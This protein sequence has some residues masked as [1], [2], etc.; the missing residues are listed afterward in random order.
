VSTLAITRRSVAAVTALVALLT[1][2]VLLVAASP[3]HAHSELVSSTPAEG[4]SV[5][6][7]GQLSLTFGEAIEPEF[8]K[9]TLTGSNNQTISLGTPKYDVAKTT[10]AI[11]VTQIVGGGTYVIGYSVLSVDGHTVAGK[12][13]FTST[14]ATMGGGMHGPDGDHSMGPRPSG[15]PGMDHDHDHMMPGDNPGAGNSSNNGS[16][17]WYAVGGA[18]LGA[19]IVAVIAWLLRRRKKAAT[20]EG[21]ASSDSDSAK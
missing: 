20:D 8:S 7:V 3:A 5:K 11:P 15:M 19:A 14:A 10:V 16:A 13:N 1:I 18:I 6:M 4:A 2:F 17:I 9:Y 21:D 12:I